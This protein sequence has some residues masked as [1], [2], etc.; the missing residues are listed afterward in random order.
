MQKE[1]LIFDDIMRTEARPKVRKVKE[2]RFKVRNIEKVV[3]DMIPILKN[4]FKDVEFDE[5]PLW[6]FEE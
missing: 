2:T 1:R 5:I 6:V 4:K 3:T